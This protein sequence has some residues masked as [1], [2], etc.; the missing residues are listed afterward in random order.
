MWQ[1]NKTSLNKNMH[2]CI[3]ND[4]KYMYD[5]ERFIFVLFQKNW[6]YQCICKQQR[7]DHVSIFVDQ[8]LKTAINF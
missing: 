8:K 5:T 1:K 4:S 6:F 2:N 7:N 3:N